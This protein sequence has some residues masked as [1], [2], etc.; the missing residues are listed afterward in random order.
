MA[1]N[2]EQNRSKRTELENTL[3]GLVDNLG[4]QALPLQPSTSDPISPPSISITSSK[5]NTSHSIDSTSLES[6][7]LLQLTTLQISL[8]VKYTIDTNASYKKFKPLSISV[9]NAIIKQQITG[10]YFIQFSRPEFCKKLPNVKK[11]I[12]AKI[13]KTLKSMTDS[14]IQQILQKCIN[15]QYDSQDL[16]VND[17]ND[18]KTSIR[19]VQLVIL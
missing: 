3:C 17:N 6:T 19:P 12:S 15:S 5:S 9:Q 7:L 14:E 18:R 8:L 11:G 4:L 16:K 13:Y 10:E 2:E 1:A